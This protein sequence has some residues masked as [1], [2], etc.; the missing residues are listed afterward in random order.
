MLQAIY[1]NQ[2][3]RSLCKFGMPVDDATN[4]VLNKY[5]GLWFNDKS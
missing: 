4:D 2:P 3:W 5:G 1:K